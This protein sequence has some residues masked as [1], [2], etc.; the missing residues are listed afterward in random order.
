[1]TGLKRK[2]SELPSDQPPPKLL[3]QTTSTTIDTIFEKDS[4]IDNIPPPILEKADS[5]IEERPR[6]IP[7]KDQ[8]NDE[9]SNSSTPPPLLPRFPILKPMRPVQQSDKYFGFDIPSDDE[10]E[11][12][13]IT[14]LA[15]SIC[16]GD[17][18]VKNESESRTKCIGTNTI[19]DSNGTNE[20]SPIT[21]KRA[22]TVSLSDSNGSNTEV[23]KS[24]LSKKGII[25]KV[26]TPKKGTNSKKDNEIKK[27]KSR[28]LNSLESLRTIQTLSSGTIIEKIMKFGAEEIIL[29]S[30]R[31]L[32]VYEFD[33]ETNTTANSSLNSSS[34][35]HRSSIQVVSDTLKSIE[36][37][38][39]PKLDCVSSEELT[40]SELS[41]VEIN[42]TAPALQKMSITSP[43]KLPKKF[44]H[45]G[46]REIVF[47][48]DTTGS[49]YGYMEEAKDR[50]K[51]LVER[52]KI[53]I[54]GVRLA[55]MAHG[56]YYDLKNDR[57]L[58]K[59]LDFGATLDEICDFFEYLPITH[60][61][62]ADECYELVLRKVR[63]S[64][65]WTT[66]SQRC[67]V[68]IGD[69]DPHEPGYQFE[70]FVNDIDWR[71]ET[72]KLNEMVGILQ[73]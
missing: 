5:F 46:I 44:I 49:M 62:D 16:V 31:S 17:C 61:G 12:D 64:L 13:T 14:K 60:G 50:M 10:E 6:A 68:I 7:H 37:G 32:A 47:S 2:P 63:D 26:I 53:D 72:Q 42:N 22:D 39:L 9:R 55:F 65:S 29:P 27:E 71:E 19:Y 18:Q 73:C 23:K 66:G 11:D 4:D 45:G 51:E 59:W 15:E 38:S 36:D 54:P 48:F 25:K 40:G 8:L 43:T 1:M 33:N 41:D 56:D 52:L 57:Y 34:V 20:N 24:K 3:K 67:L 30:D 70:E 28:L 58:I 21:L 35:L 69:S